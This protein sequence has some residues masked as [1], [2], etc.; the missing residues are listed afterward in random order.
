MKFLKYTVA[1]LAL[2]VA[3]VIFFAPIGPLPG[4]FIGGSASTAPQL[5]QDTS[6]IDEV[7]VQVAG[8]LPRVVI[9]WVV[10]QDN[11]LYV[12]GA[13]G[14]GWISMLGQ[15][16]PVQLR[17][18][19]ETYSLLA[20]KLTE[21]QLPIIAAY[22][23]KYRADYPDIGGEMGAPEDMITGASGYLLARK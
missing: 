6:Q 5:W 23:N 17:I 1:A 15:G 18:G 14:S 3:V 21:G 20:S 12:I 4:I 11:Q 2:I 19:D 22:Q 7:R 10:Q 13:N 8:T 16:G 9:I